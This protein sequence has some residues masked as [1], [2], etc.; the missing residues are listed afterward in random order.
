MQ[1]RSYPFMPHRPPSHP[2]PPGRP[3][4][5]VYCPGC[6]TQTREPWADRSP[7]R[8][9]VQCRADQC[10]DFLSAACR[11]LDGDIDTPRTDEDLERLRCIA[12]A[13]LNEHD[14]DKRWR[15]DR[16]HEKA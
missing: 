5:N 6:G 7:V 11:A 14:K 2:R 16:S 13:I 15:R 10:S 9:C 1:R 4:V 12:F 8:Y 3:L